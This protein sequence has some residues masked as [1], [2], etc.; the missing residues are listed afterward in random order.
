MSIEFREADRL[1]HL[2][3]PASSYFIE[4]IRDK[5]PAH[6][7]WFGSLRER[8]GSR[9]ILRRDRSFSPNPTAEDRSFSLDSLPLE[10][11]A[12]GRTD[13]RSPAL[14]AVG[15][16]GSMSLD[17]EYREHRI[18]AGKPALTGLPSVYVEDDTEA[19]TLVLTLEDPL[20]GLLCDLVYTVFTRR[21]V[22]TRTVKIRNGGGERIVLQRVMSLC[23][24]L[25]HS[26]FTLMQLSGAHNR[27]RHI[28]TRA[29]Y[30]GMQSVES[31]RGTSSHQQ[32]PFLALLEGDAGEDHGTVLGFSF[33]Y[34]GNFLAAVDVDQ[35]DSPRVLMGINPFDFSWTLGPGEEFQ[36][37]EAV[38][39]RS[40]E[41]LGAL[42]RT[43]HDLYRSRLCRGYHRDRERPVL[44]NNWEATYFDFDSETILNLADEASRLGIEL[45]VLDDGWFGERDNDLTSLGDWF[46]HAGKLPGGIRPLAEG[47]ISRG[48][49]FGIWVEPEMV[50]EKSRL[51][52]AHPDWC[53]RVEGR[54]PSTGRS[55]LVLDYSREDVR[56]HMV[57]T[58]CGILGGNPISYVKWDMNRHLT[59]V[60]SRLLPAERQRETSHRYVLGLYDVLERVTA[61]FPEVLFESCSGGGGRFDPGMLYYMP[62]TWTSDNTDAISRLAI[63][64]GTAL[65]YP[66]L[67]MGAHVS[68]VPNHQTGRT[69]SLKTRGAVAMGGNFGYEL[70]LLELSREEKGE[71]KEQVELFKRRRHL[72]V[73]GSYYRLLEP[74]KRTDRYAWMT[75]SPD[76][77]EALVLFV[78]VHTESN[79]PYLSL[80]C[81]GLDWDRHYSI[82]GKGAYG[83]DELMEAGIRLPYPL[84]EA[85][86]HEYHLL[87]LD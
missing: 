50:S 10:Y 75:V 66:P 82:N 85:E 18:L 36:A 60:G 48:M 62:Q 44:I 39:V 19:D 35:F 52:E 47:V 67:T 17:L 13:L 64:A 69:V 38:M 9:E 29:L 79:H 56:D 55:Q 28:H 51:Y 73:K 25:E 32:H 87:A 4:L 6:G 78:S 14:Q 76:K 40:G 20:T 24:D 23:L 31:R 34:S 3:T 61:A 68:A 8:K 12:W 74:W 83:G 46:P 37:P 22:I 58:L 59:D 16:D 70:N 43:F 49:S 15:P 1:F 65:V 33:V 41:G 77:R 42:S 5:Y 27:E 30:P 26:D 7:G 86:A 80:R 21:D 53:L 45:F 63:Q 71:I 72:I 2:K 11:S 57:E 84:L 81:K 54:H